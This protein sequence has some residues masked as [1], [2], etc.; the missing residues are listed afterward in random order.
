VTVTEAQRELCLDHP[1]V[2]YR[3]AR[4]GV[5]KA[6]KIGRV[7]DIDAASVQARKWAVQAKRSSK[8]NAAAERERKL[9]EARALFAPREAAA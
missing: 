7:W 1:D 2:V 9:A 8:S 6:R 3:L 4:A 5:L